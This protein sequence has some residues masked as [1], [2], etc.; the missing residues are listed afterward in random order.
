MK[1]KYFWY[2]FILIFTLGIILRLFNLGYSDYQG[3]EI[4]A[5][6]NPAEDGDYIQFLLEQRK[7][8]NQFIVTGLLKGLTNNF[9]NYFLTRLPFAIA[10]IFSILIFYLI[11]KKTFG[12]RIAV[13]SSIFF[14][15]NGF[16]VAFSRI[17][18]YQAFVILFGLLGIY[19]Y[20]KY[21]E[22]LQF[23]FIY[24]S[25]ISFALSI[26]FHYDGVFFSIPVLIYFIQDIL[27]A[28]ISKNK[29][30]FIQSG[31][32]IVSFLTIILTFYVPFV[33]NISEKTLDYW[34]GRISGE[35]SSKISSSYYLFTVYQP[36]Y[37]IHFY[38][39]LSF[40]GIGL[41]FYPIIFKLFSKQLSKLS[42]SYELNIEMLIIFLWAFIPF[43]FLEG[44]VSIP[45]T[46]IYT[47]LIPVFVIMA[48]GINFALEYFERN[49]LK[50][51][52]LV[53]YCGLTILGAFLYLQSYEAFVDH[54]RG[55][56][57]WQEKKFLI[58]TMNK[59]T[60]MYHLSM[61]GFP[62]Y[63]NW[64]EVGNFINN[65]DKYYTTNDRVTISRYYVKLKKDG[66]KIGYYVFSRS[67][68]TF[69]DELSNSRVKKWV[70]QG[71]K[72]VK[73]I[74]NPSKNNIEIYLL[75]ESFEKPMPKNGIQLKTEDL[76]NEDGEWG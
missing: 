32:A 22:N 57:P 66:D 42:I 30:F 8:P 20:Q 3:D 72:P 16:L 62:Y 67:P 65:S 48:Y 19:L 5:F 56:Y 69:S 33:L 58:F 68:Q 55:E 11:I 38:V 35:V 64:K 74:E 4:K 60:P 50:K 46:H 47:Y 31:G 10:G 17:V 13:L 26:L 2:S 23:K 73:I 14:V 7:G 27:K 15:T 71:N 29:Q 36:I 41:I 53:S 18:Q 59:P 12:E 43:I 70:A 40:I 61:F 76:G 52:L 24:F 1:K 54:S 37:A 9:D 39:L 51:L 49:F 45:G 6:F 25:F 63:R 21:R 75:P 34:T 44:V 28:K